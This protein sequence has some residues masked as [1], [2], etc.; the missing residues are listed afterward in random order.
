MNSMRGVS[1][2]AFRQGFLDVGVKDNDV[3]LWSK[4]LDSK[5]LL[6]TP[7]ANTVYYITF[8]DLSNGPMIFEAPPQALAIMDDMWFR[9]IS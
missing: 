5:S 3:L 9:W 1:L 6:L 7:N 4:L 8:L 2:Y